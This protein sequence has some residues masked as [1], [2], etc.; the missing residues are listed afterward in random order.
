MRD[1]GPALDT[2]GLGAINSARTVPEPNSNYI[3][4]SI[5]LIAPIAEGSMG[6]VWEAYHHRLKVRVAVKFVSDKLGE[7]TPEALARFQR[8]AAA[9][10][11]IKSAHVVRIFDSS[12]S[13]Q[14]APYMVMELL[15]GETLGDRLQ[16]ER[17]LSLQE[18][19]VLLSQVGRALD[20]AHQQGVIH[21]DI[22]PD[23]IFLCPEEE[24]SSVQP[25]FFCK[26]LDFGIAK[27]TQLPQ[28]GG[29]TTEG[30]II[31]TPEYMSPEQVLEE[32]EL[33]RRADL[34][35]L[36]VVCYV[37]L[38]LR[39][40]FRGRTL[41]Q[42]C[43]ELADP[44]PEKA[45]LLRPELSPRIDAWFARCFHRDPT[46]R[47]AS[48]KEMSKAFGVVFDGSGRVA[49][50]PGTPLA[51]QGAAIAHRSRRSAALVVGIGVVLVLL[52]MFARSSPKG[53]AIPAASPSSSAD[54]TPRTASSGGEP[55][56]T[57]SAPSTSRVASSAAPSSIPVGAA[58]SPAPSAS[59]K[60]R[61]VSPR[62]AP[63]RS[64]RPAAK[65]P[66]PKTSDRR[67]EKE[68]GF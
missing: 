48:A 11:Q 58:A 17:S 62:S 47:F 35:A 5:E 36:A 13:L 19:S 15:E 46:H 23:N 6:N 33:N 57:S 40:P 59:A 53:E 68:L 29:L 10:S 50:E 56:P 8:E 34:W 21:R 45:S 39:L 43:L 51:L 61:T 54:V 32:G 28:M 60:R 42:L 27:Q 52:F 37:A 38:T 63:G 2:V 16:Q 41:G 64:R 9:A 7:N 20:K 3:T 24:E 22:K 49:L 25:F 55:S 66:P 30:K 31:G 12:V 26:V 1:R 67:G 65:A 44:R 14:G 4:D 18:L